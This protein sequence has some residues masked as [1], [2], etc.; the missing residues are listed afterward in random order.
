[1][2][3]LAII[4]NI[5]VFASALGQHWKLL[6]SAHHLIKPHYF[7]IGMKL[8]PIHFGGML[9]WNSGLLCFIG[10]LEVSF[11]CS[12]KWADLTDFSEGVESTL[13]IHTF[14]QETLGE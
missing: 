2:F 13:L 12:W 6:A 4:L 5:L 7:K 8:M 1:M 10:T 3:I 14:K 11:L 9:A